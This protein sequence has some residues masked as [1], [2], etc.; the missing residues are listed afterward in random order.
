MSEILNYLSSRPSLSE[1]R[2]SVN[3]KGQ[4]IYKLK[5]AYSNGTTHIIFSPLHFLS[6]LSSLIPRPRTHL[7]R[8][9]GVFAP[10][11]KYRSLITPKPKEEEIKEN[12]RSYSMGTGKKT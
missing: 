7:T 1:E 4:V 11:F 5:K 12:R 10:H 8:D 2:L 6:R 9:H 3:D